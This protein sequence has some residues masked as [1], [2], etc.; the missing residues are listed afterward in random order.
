[1][2]PVAPL[3]TKIGF[4]PGGVAK[5]LSSRGGTSRPWVSPCPCTP[6]STIMQ[7]YSLSDTLDF[8][9]SQV[10]CLTFSHDGLF[11]AIGTEDGLLSVYEHR[12]RQL[13]YQWVGFSVVTA[14]LWHSERKYSLFVGEIDGRCS[15][16]SFKTADLVCTLCFCM[17]SNSTLSY[18]DHVEGLKMH[19]GPSPEGAVERFALDPASECLAIIIGRRV[20]ISQA[21]ND[22][23]T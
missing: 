14:L 23:G 15:M 13:V 22:H 21:T 12:H 16:Y 18:Q 9:T 8:V 3:A 19:L 5:R 7:Q 1:M 4:A 20:L 11:L 2:A 17:H 6:S 10:N